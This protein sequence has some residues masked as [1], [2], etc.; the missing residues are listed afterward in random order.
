M[1][2]K[3]KKNK[4]MKITLAALALAVLVLGGAAV[5]GTDGGNGADS[6]NSAVSAE[7]GEVSGG[8]GEA[9][10]SGE[11]SGEDGSPV[12]DKNDEYL[13][14]INKTHTVG[15]DYVPADLVVP[16]YYADRSYEGYRKMRQV[17]ADA[18]DELVEGAKAAGY[19]I[20]L[21]SAYRSYYAQE[22]LYN[23]YVAKDGQAAA[24]RYSAKPGT[25]EHQSGLTADVSAASVNWRLTQDFGDTDEGKWLAAHAHEYGFIIRFPEGKE[26]ITG[27]M[28][29]PWHIRYVGKE[30]AKCIY[31]QQTT[32]E[33][34]LGEVD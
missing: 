1:A 5:T 18:Y 30:H 27:Y 29:E 6:G 23:N 33:E 26:D 3:R 16:K 2:R 25:S 19:D 32:L 20:R 31:E 34:Y 8:N 17:A 11:G 15:S 9:A 24:D 28:Y 4:K 10:A 21:T 13:V 14:L 12:I 7:S 22:T